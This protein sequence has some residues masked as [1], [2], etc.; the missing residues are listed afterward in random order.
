VKRTAKYRTPGRSGGRNPPTPPT[1]RLA[2]VTPTEP[3]PIHFHGF[4]RRTTQ[5]TVDETFGRLTIDAVPVD[6]EALRCLMAQQALDYLVPHLDALTRP[7]CRRPHF[8]RAD[9]AV[10]PH[11][12]HRCEHCEITFI[13][14]VPKVSNPVIGQLP[15]FYRAFHDLYADVILVPRFPWE[16]PTSIE[17]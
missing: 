7:A 10:D 14:S 1:R 4:N 17:G 6:P 5:P 12:R 15:A 3:H 2:D 11:M 13:T 8:D 9:L 16:R